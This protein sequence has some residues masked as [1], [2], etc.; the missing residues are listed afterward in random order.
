MSADKSGGKPVATN[1]RSRWGRVRFGRHRPHALWIAAPI[2]ALGA[3]VLATI[4]VA[5]GSAGARPALGGVAI[6]LVALWPFTGIVWALIVDRSTLVGAVKNPEQS[7][8]S[9]WHD[10]AASGAFADTLL[11]G[12]LGTVAITLSGVEPSAVFAV[13][14]V[15]LLSM[16]SFGVRYFALSR[17]R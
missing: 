2:G 1:D 12:G 5:T 8:E 10:R 16:V 11:I 6:A 14:A 13:A 9:F 17:Q 15:V 4:A 7:V 3:A